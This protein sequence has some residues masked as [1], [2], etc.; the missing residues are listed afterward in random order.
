[1]FAAE[2]SA[3]PGQADHRELAGDDQDP[4]LAK[5]IAA[6]RIPTGAHPPLLRYRRIVSCPNATRYRPFSPFREC[7]TAILTATVLRLDDTTEC[8]G[9]LITTEWKSPARQSAEWT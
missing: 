5:S 2:I 6:T 4:L 3:A 8:M 9:G 1:L 7:P